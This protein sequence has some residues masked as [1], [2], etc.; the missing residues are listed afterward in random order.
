MKLTEICIY[1]IKSCQGIKLTSAQVTAKGLKDS[2][3]PAFYDR[4]FMLVDEKGQFLTQRQYPLMARI[5]VLIKNETLIITKVDTSIQPFQLLVNN[6]K[7][8]KKVTIWGDKILGIDQGDEVAKWFQDALN[9]THTCRLI[10]QSDHHIRAID[11]RYSFKKNQPVS[12]ADGYPFLLTNTASLSELNNRLKIKY[13]QQNQQITMD[14]F[15]PNLVIESD[16]PFIEDSWQEIKI[17]SVKFS[18]VK[19]CSRC[20]ITTTDQKTGI[21]NSLKEPLNTL[22]NFRQIP[23]QGIMFGQNLIAYNEGVINLND[24]VEFS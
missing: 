15:R 2:I 10:R 24:S 14:R 19:A 5:K 13:P 4:N 17:N 8:K 21:Q 1:P 6:N 18:L 16:K 7:P 23:K 20:L 12:L 3:N 9:L 11:S 22:S